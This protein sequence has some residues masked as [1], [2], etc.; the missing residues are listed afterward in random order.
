MASSLLS[1]LYVTAGTAEGQRLAAFTTTAFADLLRTI[2]GLAGR[3]FGD[4]GPIPS[5]PAVLTGVP[6]TTDTELEM[7]IE[8]EN[9]FHVLIENRIA[10]ETDWF[11]ERVEARIPSHTDKYI[12]AAKHRHGGAAKVLVLARAHPDL[13]GRKYPPALFAG[14]RSWP[15]ISRR[16]QRRVSRTTR[17]RT[18]SASSSLP[19]ITI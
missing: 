18:A 2:P 3:I 4:L 17:H 15:E 7:V 13:S 9:G 1:E 14:S 12:A 8:G 6:A 5:R 10:P 19:R 16:S 11:E